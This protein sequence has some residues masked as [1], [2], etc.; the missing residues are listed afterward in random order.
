M[1]RNYG[2]KIWN[3]AGVERLGAFPSSPSRAIQRTLTTVQKQETYESPKDYHRLARI[4]S[5]PDS[6]S[7]LHESCVDWFDEYIEAHGLDVV[8][9]HTS[10]QVGGFRE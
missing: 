4:T 2:R 6:E 8:L 10:N 3:K 1:K 7:V 5:D 9:N